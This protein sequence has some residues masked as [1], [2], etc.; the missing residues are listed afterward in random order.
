MD[1]TSRGPQ[2]REVEIGRRRG[3]AGRVGGAGVVAIAVGLAVGLVLACGHDAKP[4]VV[5][6]DDHPPLPP[7]SGTP[8]GY[9]VDDAAELKLSDAQLA[10]LKGI[11][12]DLAAKLE[13]LDAGARGPAP[14]A[15]PSPGQNG[16][17]GRGLGFRAGGARGGAGGRMNSRSG[18]GSAVR[19][20]PG[21]TSPDKLAS[22]GEERARDVRA[23]IDD[24]FAQ[25][26]IVQRVIAKRVLADRGV[27]LDAG[28]PKAA[29]TEAEE[30][31]EPGEPDS[32]SGA[33]SN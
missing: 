11:D 28:R 4:A 23:A 31:G 29:P 20:R 15:G 26:D 7:A 8:I 6:P 14:V 10:K 16:R 1:P 32:G 22:T 2:H 12:E 18:S 9:L 5:Q 30:P 17:R 19:Q 21:A 25:L 27:D 3:G 13:A 33:G 24:A